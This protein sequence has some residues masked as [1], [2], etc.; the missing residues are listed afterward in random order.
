MV[1]LVVLPY[2]L[3]TPYSPWIFLY[4]LFFFLQNFKVLLTQLQC[5]HNLSIHFLHCAAWHWDWWLWWPAGLLF[6]QWLCSSLRRHCDQSQQNKI[7][8]TS[9]ALQAPW[10]YGPGTFGNHWAAC[11]WFSCC[12][13]NRCW[14]SRSGLWIFCVPYCQYLWV[15]ASFDVTVWLVPNELLGPLFDNLGFHEGSE[16]RHGA[17]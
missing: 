1:V 14:A 8:C 5:A 17:K 6:P 15:S 4:I 13:H 11:A 12:S 9:A 16:G 7:C 3:R 10:R 2:I